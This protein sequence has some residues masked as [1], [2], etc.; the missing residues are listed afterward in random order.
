MLIII[1]IVL[2]LDG[3]LKIDFQWNLRGDWVFFYYLL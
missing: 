1:Y 3:G 2:N